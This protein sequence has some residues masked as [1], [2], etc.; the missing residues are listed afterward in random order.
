VAPLAARCGSRPVGAGLPAGKRGGAP[1]RLGPPGQ[2]L[3]VATDAG[4]VDAQITMLSDI[5]RIHG[6]LGQFAEA[7]QE[8]ER[9]TAIAEREGRVPKAMENRHR[10]ALFERAAGNTEQARSMLE[11]LRNE[12]RSR[13]LHRLEVEV[14]HSLAREALEHQE[15]RRA[16]VLLIEAEAIAHRLGLIRNLSYIRLD[17]AYALANSGRQEDARRVYAALWQSL[18]PLQL[19]HIELLSRF[20]PEAAKV[21]GDTAAG[22]L[23]SLHVRLNMLTQPLGMY[24]TTRR[25]EREAFLQSLTYTV[26]SLLTPIDP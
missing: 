15:Y 11:E 7:V 1:C 21:F 8:L 26:T 24:E 9:S 2:A 12:T 25:L 23:L 18:Q 4:D 17:L 20:L 13:S 22:Q 19:V 3:D 10:Q 14:L 16:R 5:A 6:L